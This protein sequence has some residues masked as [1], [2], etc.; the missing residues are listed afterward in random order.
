MIR[1]RLSL[2]QLTD[3]VVAKG[4][5]VCVTDSTAT[6]RVEVS[7]LTSVSLLLCACVGGGTV[8]PLSSKSKQAHA[9][10]RKRVR[11]PRNL[12]VIG[13]LLWRYRKAVSDSREIY[14]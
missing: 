4:S 14:H 9:A 11:V 6:A 1:V 13:L 12:A 7:S 2:P 3:E 10:S 5:R 8:R